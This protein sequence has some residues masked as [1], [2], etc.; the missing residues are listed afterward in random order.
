MQ[1]NPSPRTAE[2]A[3]GLRVQGELRCVPTRLLCDCPPVDSDTTVKKKGSNLLPLCQLICYQDGNMYVPLVDL[4]LVEPELSAGRYSHIF[5]FVL[6]NFKSLSLEDEQRVRAYCRNI[7]ASRVA[8]FEVFLALVQSHTLIR[9]FRERWRMRDPTSPSAMR[10]ISGG[11]GSD[12]SVKRWRRQYGLADPKR[13]KR[14]TAAL[15]KAPKGVT[16]RKRKHRRAQPRSNSRAVQTR[17]PIDGGSSP[18]RPS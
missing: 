1:R 6:T 10:V 15:P 3:P 7:G 17:L 18:R 8:V 14:A 5:A 4:T 11:R 2:I 12:A 16:R 9:Y 13:Q